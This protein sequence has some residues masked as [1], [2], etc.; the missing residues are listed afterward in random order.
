VERSRVLDLDRLVYL[1]AQKTGSTFLS[2]FLAVHSGLKVRSFAKHS[3]ITEEQFGRN[4]VSFLISIRRP[5]P[6]YISLFRYGLDGH[7]EI[8]HKMK[9]SGRLDLYQPNEAC[10]KKFLEAVNDGQNYGLQTR[11][12]LNIMNL[13]S[14]TLFPAANEDNSRYRIEDFIRI[15]ELKLDLLRRE[16]EWAEFGRLAKLVENRLALT[17]LEYASKIKFGLTRRSP[18]W[19]NRIRRNRSK[20]KLSVS[21]DFLDS[22]DSISGPLGTIE[23]PIFELYQQMALR[24]GGRGG[25]KEVHRGA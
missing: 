9:R 10:F 25:S 4:E 1:D 7:G 18:E 23:R 6:Y 14:P 20:T 3:P 19:R 16:A 22:L 15:E 5:G 17:G 12:L 2:D 11:R 8:F 13:N 21:Q 24:F